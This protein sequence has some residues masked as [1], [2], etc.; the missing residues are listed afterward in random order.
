MPLHPYETSTAVVA[1]C[2]RL[3][4]PCCR[5]YHKHETSTARYLHGQRQKTSTAARTIP[6]PPRPSLPHACVLQPMPPL[7]HA[8]DL[9]ANVVVVAGQRPPCRHRRCRTPTSSTSTAAPPV[10]HAGVLHLHGRCCRTHPSSTSTAAVAAAT[11]GY[12]GQSVIHAAT[13]K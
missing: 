2:R 9:H 7:P 8:R 10:R 3:P 13:I 12:S 11:A 4:P 5:R 6:P 1:A